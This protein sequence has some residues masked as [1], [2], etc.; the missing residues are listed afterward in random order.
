MADPVAAAVAARQGIIRRV[1]ENAQPGF[2]SIADTLRQARLQDAAISRSDV[3]TFMEGVKAREDRPQRG[4]NSYEPLH[5]LQVDLADMSVFSSGPYRYLLVAI[6]TFTKKIAA[7]PL[8]R[9]TS[10]ATAAAW[11]KVVENLGIPSYVY[12]ND[13]TEFKLEF[14]DKLDFFDVNKIVTRGHAYMVE[15]A[16]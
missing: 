10:E 7:V 12:S 4:Y 8:T 13:G 1:Y 6:D 15:R 14:K 5:Q 16:I 2:G 3:V 11:Q 9:K